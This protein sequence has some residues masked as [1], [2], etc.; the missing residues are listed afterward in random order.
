MTDY[1][2]DVCLSFAGEDRE[3]VERV[4]STLRD[5]GLAVFYDKFE[6]ANLWGKNLVEYFVSV[7][8]DNAQFCVMFVS[9]QY[10]AKIWP[11]HERRSALERALREG[12]DYL[13]PV[14]FDDTEVP[15]LLR[16]IGFLDAREYTPQQLAHI[17][18]QKLGRESGRPLAPS[19]EHLGVPPESTHWSDFVLRRATTYL[20]R[21]ADLA[22]E[23]SSAVEGAAYVLSIPTP[24]IVADG[25]LAT[26][27]NSLV[28]GDDYFGVSDISSTIATREFANAI[29]SAG[30]RGVRVRYM[31]CAMRHDDALSEEDVRQAAEALARLLDSSAGAQGVAIRVADL[32]A[33]H[34]R[35]MTPQHIFT[36]AGDAVRLEPRRPDYGEISYSKL[37]TDAYTSESAESAWSAGKTVAHDTSSSFQSL[38]ALLRQARWRRE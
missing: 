33:A 20:Q 11:S 27:V 3:Y 29:V 17:L 22:I 34:A 4:A 19:G 23:L 16:T 28:R 9:A 10:A 30:A 15:G 5:A 2:F 7:Y 1:Q 36:H 35:F 12:S 18:I 21:A 38:W 37:A 26:F 13:L 24:R 14:R 8:R 31:V 25:M 32:S 6:V